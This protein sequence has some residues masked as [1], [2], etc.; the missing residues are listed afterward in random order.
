MK[1]ENEINNIIGR[2]IDMDQPDGQGMSLGVKNDEPLLCILNDVLRY[3][4]AY[5]KANDHPI[6]KDS[7][8][9]DYVRDILQG[10]EGMLS[11]Q[12]GVALERNVTTDSKDNGIMSDIICFIKEAH[13]I[14]W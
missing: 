10:V 8:C 2:K 6:G 14:E 11:M 1:L 13:C 9:H 3:C 5:R 4:K 7:Y 12:G